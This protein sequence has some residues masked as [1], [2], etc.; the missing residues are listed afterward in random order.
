MKKPIRLSLIKHNV[1]LNA[2]MLDAS[3]VRWSS[4]FHLST[5]LLEKIGLLGSA[6]IGFNRMY[7]P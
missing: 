6:P 4:R 7:D 2:M 5:T 1:E 3:T